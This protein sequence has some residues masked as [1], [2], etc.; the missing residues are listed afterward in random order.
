MRVWRIGRLS[1]P[2][3]LS[4]VGGLYVSG[5]WH[6]RGHRILYTSATPSLAALEVLVH[7]DPALAPAGLC[8]LEIDVPDGIV[9]ETVDPSTLTPKWQAYPFPPELQD[10]GSRWLDECR[11]A[12]LCVSSTSMPVEQNYLVNP[13]HP[14]SARIQVVAELAFAFD[15]RLLTP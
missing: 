1:E 6:Y 7:V 3:K 15:P 13:D 11:T 14:D 5:R 12:L 9:I 10:F 4:G 8:I 2:D